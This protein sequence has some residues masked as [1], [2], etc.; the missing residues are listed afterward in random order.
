MSSSIGELLR[1]LMDE[2]HL[3]EPELARA[4]GVKRSTINLIIREPSRVPDY[5]NLHKL[6][7][8]FDMTTDQ[9]YELAV[10]GKST[11]FEEKHLALMDIAPEL[12]L[13]A[14]AAQTLE[15]VKRLS[16]I[17]IR[18]YS[19]IIDGNF[20][21]QKPVD[22][23]YGKPCNNPES[24]IGYL[25]DNNS[26][27][28]GDPQINKGDILIIN[29]DLTPQDGNIVITKR[30]EDGTMIFGKYFAERGS[31]II[32]NKNGNYEI[33]PNDIVHVVASIRKRIT[34]YQ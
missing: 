2:R 34:E 3:S 27:D 26:Y 31:H 1:K 23:I 6:A 33:K 18:V 30:Q 32:H 15:T 9:F 11:A 10:S 22:I 28:M 7:E 16:P 24:W 29:L 19:S 8:Y 13:D 12:R 5:L 21:K 25:A 20:K 4:S 17:P 14:L